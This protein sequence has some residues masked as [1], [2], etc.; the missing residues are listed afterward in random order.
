MA[1]QTKAELAAEN[2]RLKEQADAAVSQQGAMLDMLSEMQQRLAAIEASG[3][4]VTQA[5]EKVSGEDKIKSEMQALAEEF[6]DYPAIDVIE[7]HVL[8]GEDADTA[9]RLQDEPGVSQDP[10][11]KLRTWKLRWFNF[12]VEGRASR[13][14]REGYVKVEWAELQDAE[15][16]AS[17]ERKDTFVRRGDR[18]LEVLCKM[19]LRLYEFKKRV[20]AQRAQGL[21]T[22][23]AKLRD[24][25]AN[26]VAAKA[27][28]FGDN[29][30]QA[31]SFAHGMEVSI[32]RGERESVTL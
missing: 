15:G 28:T 13:A 5:V 32:T 19:P 4:A 23:E 10:T 17:S 2:E 25:L 9:L 20:A 31:G 30:D 27:G 29:A 16:L 8:Q 11:G 18:G 21:L 22:S 3:G 26:G 1:E 6:A 14:S 7:R 24:H 12:G